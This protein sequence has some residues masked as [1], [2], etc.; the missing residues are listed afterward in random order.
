MA[1][2]I[3]E[4][5]VGFA[6]SSQ[7]NLGTVNN[8]PGWGRPLVGF[9]TGQDPLYAEIKAHV[10][11]FYW[12][13]IDILR[14]GFPDMEVAPSQ[15]TVIAWILPQTRATKMDSREETRFP[16]ERWARSR[17]AG[18]EFNVKLRRHLVSLLT[19]R[20]YEA[21]APQLSPLW[22]MHISEKYGLAST[23]SERHAAYV[24]G[25]GTFGLCD[26]LITP[27]G[28]AVRCGS[29][30]ARVNIDATMR[31]YRDHDEYCLFLQGG[32]CGKC[33]DRCPAGAI[34]K[35]GHNKEKCKEYIDTVTTSYIKERYGLNIY[36]CGL[37]QTGVPCESK[38]P[39]RKA[40]PRGC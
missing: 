16:A 3:R 6:A 14:T 18:E 36:G 5:I 19:Q 25:L 21:I 38:I 9:S 29:V 39:G 31:P 7:N 12:E 33:M 15:V 11:T 17:Q 30:V 20:G 1:A 23:W 8:E 27:V 4:E 24:S 37:C 34:T 28:K 10:G 22:A 40:R 32:T 13:P 2:W 26:G 35:E